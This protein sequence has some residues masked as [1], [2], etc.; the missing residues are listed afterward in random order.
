[1]S[2]LAA[3]P[4]PTTLPPMRT[5]WLLSAAAHAGLFIAINVFAWLTVASVQRQER[6]FAATVAT[7]QQAAQA[8]ARTEAHAAAIEAAK[9]RLAMELA[10][11]VTSEGQSAE[12]EEVLAA[13]DEGLAGLFGEPEEL[14]DDQLAADG[15][16]ALDLG[17]RTAQDLLKRELV[18]EVRA[19]VRTQVAPELKDRIERELEAQAGPAIEQGLA[20]AVQDDA[21]RAHRP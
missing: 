9:D 11:A 7:R 1:M 18:A 21:A 13:T 3:P 16:A 20:A 2:T 5:P 12:A 14:S 19:Y 4:A 15:I 10:D 17:Q 6:A 8:K